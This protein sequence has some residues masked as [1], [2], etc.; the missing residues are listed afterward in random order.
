MKCSNDNDSDSAA[1]LDLLESLFYN[2]MML[3]DES[4]FLSPD[5]MGCLSAD[6]GGVAGNAL[7]NAGHSQ[8]ESWSHVLAEEEAIT[9][10]E[11]DLLQH[12]GVSGPM[13]MAASSAPISTSFNGAG[14]T[15]SADIE[16]PHLENDV[17]YGRGGG[18]NKRK[19][20][21][22]WLSITIIFSKSAL[23]LTLAES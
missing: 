20:Y 3:L 2:E 14:S 12:F 7:N 11:R 8:I 4:S 22:P 15:S 21:Y 9:L 18:T 5:F 6:S 16:E 13:M 17:L 19:F 10:A 1:S 23:H